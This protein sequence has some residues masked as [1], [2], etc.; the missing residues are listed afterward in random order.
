MT[1][2]TLKVSPA[3]APNV[4]RFAADRDGFIGTPQRRSAMH[5]GVRGSG[6]LREK[7]N[8]KEGIIRLYLK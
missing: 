3:V 4:R 6:S 8:T 5:H 1:R 7:G 2:V